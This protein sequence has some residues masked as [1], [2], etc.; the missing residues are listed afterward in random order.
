MVLERG[1]GNLVGSY[2][3][4]SSG[5]SGRL[6]AYDRMNRMIMEHSVG[7]HNSWTG[8]S[9][10]NGW[11]RKQV[12]AIQHVVQAAESVQGKAE[13]RDVAG[14]VVEIHVHLPVPSRHAVFFIDELLYVVDPVREIS[15]GEPG[16]FR[17]QPGLKL[18]FPIVAEG[19]VTV[20][21]APMRVNEVECAR[22]I[23]SV[24]ITT[25]SGHLHAH[26]FES[27]WLCADNALIMLT[28]HLPAIPTSLRFTRLPLLPSQRLTV[29]ILADDYAL[30]LAGDVKVHKWRCED[31]A[32]GNEG[33]SVEIFGP[34]EVE[35]RPGREVDFRTLNVTL[36][37][38]VANRRYTLQLAAAGFELMRLKNAHPG[39][40]LLGSTGLLGLES[41]LGNLKL[42]RIS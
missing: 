12:V 33:T 11:T 2:V 13:L 1:L 41:Q 36:E 37:V 39:L 4:L 8:W 3:V 15:I 31:N 19:K 29:S 16:S 34:Y 27:R 20:A 14:E 32:G 9:Y 28:M 17:L 26:L 35:L 6:V 21:L 38:E 18:Q 42:A 40:A 10:Q 23:S 22:P 7:P 24:E 25:V 30:P 5:E